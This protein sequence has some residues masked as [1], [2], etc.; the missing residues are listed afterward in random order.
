MAKKQEDKVEKL[1]ASVEYKGE[2]ELMS[3]ISS[4]EPLNFICE[5]C[6]KEYKT[7][8]GYTK[9]VDK[10][11]VPVEDTQYN[12]EK[13]V[14]SVKTYPIQ[15]V[16]ETVIIVEPTQKD[17]YLSMINDGSFILK[18]NGAIIFDSDVDKLTSLGFSDSG[19]S[20]GIKT[21]PYDGLNFKYKK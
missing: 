2:G 11:D 19:F 4:S 17:K 13:V 8:S 12:V 1:N 18:V 15:V 20:I 14:E 5:K 3:D 10:C 9:H 16:T 6:G 21:F 7:K